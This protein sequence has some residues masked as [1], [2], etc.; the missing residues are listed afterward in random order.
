MGM[1]H[2]KRQTTFTKKGHSSDLF[3]DDHT[4]P[5][6]AGMASCRDVTRPGSPAP[7]YRLRVGKM[8]DKMERVQLE[9]VAASF[10]AS[11][12]TTSA[13]GR[14]TLGGGASASRSL[15]SDI[16]NT[17]PCVLSSNSNKCSSSALC[18]D[19]VSQVCV[20]RGPDVRNVSYPNR[21]LGDSV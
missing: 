10:T 5:A 14:D 16:N 4:L 18:S 9:N 1:R 6:V 17:P 13:F 21:G 2:S 20:A 15:T 8:A 7:A 12:G 3:S 11:G 19:T